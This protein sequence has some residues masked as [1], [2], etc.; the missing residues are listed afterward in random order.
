MRV[1]RRRYHPIFIEEDYSY[2]PRRGG[3]L[4]KCLFILV[5]F[6]IVLGALYFF[7]Q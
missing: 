4:V 2:R 6:S 1:F 5:S 7:I 3:F